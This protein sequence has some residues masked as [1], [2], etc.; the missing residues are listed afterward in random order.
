MATSMPTSVDEYMASQPESVRSKLDEVRSAIRT[1]I[2]EAE[3]TISY[4]MPTYK[5]DGQR[6]MFFAGW[7]KHFS[8][9]P[10][11]DRLMAAFPKELASFEVLKGTIR[12]PF[13][14]PVP[15][16]LIVRIARFRAKE[17]AENRKSTSRKR[18]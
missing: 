7:K 16:D 4:G 6:V 9:Y 12:I 8:L 2:P 14:R 17:V 11:S 15:V 3:E 5:L 18:G 10:A 1:A 13:S